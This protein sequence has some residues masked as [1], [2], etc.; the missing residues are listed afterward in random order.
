MLC[1]W[2]GEICTA[3]NPA[4]PSTFSHSDAMSVHL[5]S[6][7]WTNTS[8]E[9]MWPLARYV[10]ARLGRSGTEPPGMMGMPESWQAAVRTISR[11]A[12]RRRA[13]TVRFRGSLNDSQLRR[14]GDGAA[15]SSDP[16]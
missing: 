16:G 4:G 6:N 3:V 13:D 9:A 2:G 15:E 8:P 5:H 1:S 12:K 10:G 11:A 7:R 14:R